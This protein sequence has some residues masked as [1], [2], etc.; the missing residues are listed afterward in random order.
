MPIRAWC[1]ATFLLAGLPLAAQEPGRP[2]ENG[3]NSYSLEKE[4]ALGRQLAW[5][6]YRHTTAVANS[7]VED[8]VNRLGRRISAQMPEPSSAF[9]FSVIVD[10][11]CPKT[12]EP[13]AVPGGYI[14]VPGALFIAAHDE[15]EFAGM[16]AHAMEHIVQRHLLRQATP[17][18]ATIP[19]IPLGPCSGG[20]IPVGYLPTQ[21]S[22]ELEADAL[23]V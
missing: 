7:R 8:Y 12:H 10:D 16:L 9:T 11:L 17:A 6:V 4:A 15:A 23:A 1:H 22:N 21:R 20:M 13:G 18:G 14:F 5:E 3:V 2:T 19:L